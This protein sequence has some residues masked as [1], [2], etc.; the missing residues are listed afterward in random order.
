MKRREFINGWRAVAFPYR[1]MRSKPVR[2]RGA[3][4]QRS[5]ARRSRASSPWRPIATRILYQGAFGLADIGEG[6]PPEARCAVPDRLDDQGGHLGRRHAA[7]RAGPPGP[8][9]SGGEVSAAA[10]QAV[11][12]RV[13][14]RGDRRL[15]AAP[16]HQVHH[17]KAPLHAHERPRLRLHEPDGSRFQAARRRGVSGRARS[18]SS[19]A[20]N[21]ST[22]PAR[23]GSAAWSRRSPASSSRS[24]FASTYSSR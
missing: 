4:A 23:T 19:P 10:R 6:R 11:G 13:V 18:C 3:C 21:G 1:Q 22:A 15:Q 2:R 17:R 16:R 9:R 24:I 7:H 5:N 14:R 8:R 12:V 20:S